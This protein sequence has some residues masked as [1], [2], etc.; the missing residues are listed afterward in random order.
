VR[1]VAEH[2]WE[3]AGGVDCMVPVRPGSAA[4]ARIGRLWLTGVGAVWDAGGGEVV[5]VMLGPREDSVV[6]V[7]EGGGMWVAVVGAGNA[8]EAVECTAC[9]SG[10]YVSLD[11]A[12]RSADEVWFSAGPS[13]PADNATVW[14]L[15]L[16][17]STGVLSA[18]VRQVGGDF[19]DGVVRWRAA[20]A[21]GRVCGHTSRRVVCT[22][23]DQGEVEVLSDGTNASLRYMGQAGDDAVFWVD[24]DDSQLWMLHVHN[25]NRNSNGN[26]NNSS[27]NSTEAWSIDIREWLD[28]DD[29]ATW[30]SFVSDPPHGMIYAATAATLHAVNAT[31]ARSWLV[32]NLTASGVP[33][34][35]PAAFEA[36]LGVQCTGDS[37][38]C[39]V[40]VRAEHPLYGPELWALE[41]S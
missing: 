29:E 17:N 20:L 30:M 15:S 41:V 14:A 28:D 35:R 8:V 32:A 5:A 6:V 27:A 26:G 11:S 37:G 24:V 16:S 9:P 22:G 23:Q 21:D 3:S 39:A 13:S 19:T 34:T 1:N 33:Q 25:S 38:A 40:F 12:L 36:L 2:R 7:V 10:H 18:Q 4:Y 31:D